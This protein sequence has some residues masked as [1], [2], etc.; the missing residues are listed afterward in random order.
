MLCANCGGECGKVAVLI[1]LVPE[2]RMRAYAD[3]AVAEYARVCAAC[4]DALSPQQGSEVGRANVADADLSRGEVYAVYVST[5][6]DGDGEGA[7]DVE[8]ILCRHGEVAWSVHT[9]DDAGGSDD[10]PGILYAT[11]REAEVAAY[12]L[13]DEK[14]EASGEDAKTYLRRLEDEAAAAAKTDD[15]GSYA[16]V[17]EAAGEP[18]RIIS[19]HP[20]YADARAALA[21]MDREFRERNPTSSSVTLLC[22]F[23]IR[24][25][26]DDTGRWIAVDDDG[27]AYGD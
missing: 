9:R 27:M 20:T 17:W 25:F 13:A 21:P 12:A 18:G 7:C 23:E 1:E 16:I 19:T 24:T 8:V 15:A 14:D 5:F 10:G 4:A 11:E 2:D 22:G 6:P 3:D 26:D